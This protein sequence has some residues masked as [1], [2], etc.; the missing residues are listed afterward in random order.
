[1][2]TSKNNKSKLAELVL[3]PSLFPKDS[4]GMYKYT[5]TGQYF[6]YMFGDHDLPIATVL[7]E[8][9]TTCAVQQDEIT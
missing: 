1:M 7:N 9:Q 3:G 4:H 6:M 8:M 2:I 5:D